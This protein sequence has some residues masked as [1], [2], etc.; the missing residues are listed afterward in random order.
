MYAV[1]SPETIQL[2]PGAMMRLPGTWHDYCTLREIRGDGSTPRIKYRDG[3]IL[4]M[5][6]LPIHGRETHLI[7]RLVGYVHPNTTNSGLCLI[8][9]HTA[10]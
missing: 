2:P 4:L 3:E 1:V 8:N 5:N 10:I 7:A 9:L 6:P